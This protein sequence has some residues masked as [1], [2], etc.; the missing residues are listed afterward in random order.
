MQKDIFWTAVVV[1]P[2]FFAFWTIHTYFSLVVESSRNVDKLT[3]RVKVVRD[4][5]M[6]FPQSSVM[7]EKLRE[8]SHLLNQ[9]EE[10]KQVRRIRQRN[11]L[12]KSLEVLVDQL[13][14]DMQRL[15]ESC[16]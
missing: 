16:R 12:C 7:A 11:A 14:E 10:I 2:A 15:S 6:N 4:Q 1:V 8:I 5:C 13:E 9:I 3:I